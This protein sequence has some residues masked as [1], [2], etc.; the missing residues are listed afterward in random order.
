MT[1][2]SDKH[3]RIQ[4]SSRSKNGVLK[5]ASKL[6]LFLNTGKAS[7]YD[8]KAIDKNF[9]QTLYEDARKIKQMLEEVRLRVPQSKGRDS[10]DSICSRW[11]TW[12]D[13]LKSAGPLG[14]CDLKLT[15][16][17][18][19]TALVEASIDADSDLFRLLFSYDA[20][21][22]NYIRKSAYEVPSAKEI[23]EGAQDVLD[24]YSTRQDL[25]SRISCS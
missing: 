17:M 10:I 16:S 9:R 4:E 3:H 23:V 11:S 6:Q 21:I 13:E 14:Y 2:R 8:L 7:K 25:M 20:M 1:F 15:E 18:V 22:A 12:L 5:L 24:A 19:P